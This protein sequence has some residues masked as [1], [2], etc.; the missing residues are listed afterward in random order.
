M[1]SAASPAALS[2]TTGATVPQRPT[3]V[4]I[5]LFLGTLSWAIP[6]QASLLVLVPA[7]V[8]DL[9]PTDKVGT[10]AAVSAVAATLGLLANVL[11]GA[12]SDRTRT[13]FGGR[14]PW[15]VGG[16]VGSAV[17]LQLVPR[18]SSV[19]LLM[20]VFA[21][22]V[23]AQNATMASLTALIP[24]RVAVGGRA[25][26]SA[27]I[28]IGVLV[29][30]SVGAAAAAGFTSNL[31]AGFALVAVVEVVLAIAAVIVAPEPANKNQPRTAFS[32]GR[33]LH[34]MA[35][36]RGVAD[37]YWALWGRLL[38]VLGY[39]LIQTFQLYIFTDYVHLDEAAAAK[40]IAM[41]ALIFLAAAIVGSL[42]AGPLSDRLHR[43]KIFVIVASIL[44]ALSAV[45]PLLSATVAG[46]V[47][48]ALIGGVAFGCY[49]AT[50]T[51][52]VTE[53]LPDDQT[54]AKDLAILNAANAG[55]QILAPVAAGG[56]IALGLGF[57]PLFLV[58]IVACIAGAGLIV[59][60][61]RVP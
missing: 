47:G 52:L 39:F 40:V 17:L 7:R 24:D 46:M 57:P 10:F 15:I 55:G 12:L 45:P 14:T 23:A 61:K 43:R 34:S 20:I 16:A 58:S 26:V 53:L 49:Y 9:T 21:V 37:F 3:R 5:A 19:P 59:P 18:A 56:I 41:N 4:A 13:R 11:F 29:G 6:F 38:L 28:G 32:V 48:F 54:R 33:L 51:A 36:P 31:A 1:S 44:A 42:I 8:A 60:I 22:A 27:T 50:D 30:T 2:V 35:P 25:R